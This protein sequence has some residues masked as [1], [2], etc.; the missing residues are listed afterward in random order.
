M[1][2]LNIKWQRLVESG[3]TCPRCSNTE[4]EVERAF[5]LLSKAL[6]VFGIKVEL[7]KSEI[8]LEEFLTSPLNSN[9]IIINNKPLEQWLDA[10]VGSSKCCSV[11]GDNEC[12]TIEIGSDKYET[13]PANM[14]I[15]AGLKAAAEMLPISE[16][17][18]F[19]S[20]NLNRFNTNK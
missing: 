1:L 15:K 17:I 2:T 10:N 18:K 16:N 11:C 7:Q 6:S 8:T 13:I 9:Q 19:V 20:L 12:R 5:D 3:E 14:I 4:A